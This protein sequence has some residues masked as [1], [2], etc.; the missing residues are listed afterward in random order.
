MFYLGCHLVDLVLQLQGVPE[1]VFPFNTATGIDGVYTEDLGFA[2]LKY[3]HGVSVIRMGGAEIGAGKRRQLVICG[4]EGTLEIRPLEDAVPDGGKFMLF[5]EQD[6]HRISP[7]TGKRVS[8]HTKSQPFQ[9]YEAMLAAFAEM[10]RGE[11]ENPYTCDYELTLFKTILR[12]C[13]MEA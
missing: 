8:E 9:R 11:R 2:V 12:C 6:E 13:G 4:S 10:V 3:P 1:Q 5:T 7:E